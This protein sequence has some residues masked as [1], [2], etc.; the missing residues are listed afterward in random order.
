MHCA[1]VYPNKNVFSLLM[2]QR[3]QCIEELAFTEK[4]N[5]K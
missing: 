4:N 3:W 5:D 1:A 2:Q